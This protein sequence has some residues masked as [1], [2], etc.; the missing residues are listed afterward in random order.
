MFMGLGAT[1]LLLLAG[2]ILLAFGPKAL[3]KAV[4]VARKVDSARRELSPASLVQRA[5]K[6]ES[7]KKPQ[8]KRAAGEED[9]A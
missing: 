5:L 6:P 2:I 8:A 3:G 7:K 9:E 1:E 4:R